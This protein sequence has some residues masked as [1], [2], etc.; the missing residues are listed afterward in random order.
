MVFPRFIFFASEGCNNSVIQEAGC[1]REKGKVT[2]YSDLF[3]FASKLV[4]IFVP[5]T[6]SL[7]FNY[8]PVA[9]GPLV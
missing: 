2:V 1:F 9:E 8:L 3:M 5:D 6:D 7:I 4:R